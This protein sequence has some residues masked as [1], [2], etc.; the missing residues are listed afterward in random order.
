PFD[1]GAKSAALFYLRAGMVIMACADR[2]GA[3][4]VQALAAGAHHPHADGAILFAGISDDRAGG[5]AAAHLPAA[6]SAAGAAD[7]WRSFRAGNAAVRRGIAG[8]G[9]RRESG[10]ER[11]RLSP[12][13]AQRG[14]MESRGAAH[15]RRG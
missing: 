11:V 13:K 15:Q 14:G 8:A 3:Q 7:W 4:T 10:S 1:M 5:P 9:R 6:R 12:R 2:A